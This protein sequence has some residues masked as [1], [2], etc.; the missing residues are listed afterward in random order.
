MKDNK[1]NLEKIKYPLF[2]T[3]YSEIPAK[4]LYLIKYGTLP[5]K[6][7]TT[8][9][10]NEKVI[11]FLL[12]NGYSVLTKSN[13]IKETIIKI[14]PR[15]EDYL[16]INDEFK[17][18][19]S[20][21]LEAKTKTY[22]LIF[23]Y[24]ITTTSI[25]TNSLLTVLEQFKIKESKSNIYIIKS[26]GSGNL[27]GIGYDIANP[28]ID[29]ELNYGKEFKKVHDVIIKRLNTENDKGIILL[30]GKSGTGKTY[31]LRYLTKCIDN[32]EIYFVPPALT[33]SLTDPAIIPFLME[34]K[35]SILIIED[36]EKIITDRN[37]SSSSNGVANILNLTDGILGD[38]LNI[39]IIVTFN[40]ERSQIDKAMT[41]KGRLIAEHSFDCLN[42]EDT[43]N[44]LSALGKNRK[45]DKELTLAEIYNIDEEEYTSDKKIKIGFK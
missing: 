5:S 17:I 44:L 22:W 12:S 37:L 8:A 7:S 16:L 36:G 42:V 41:R 28:I 4:Q 18:F 23:Y 21:E 26:D 25:E 34:R 3:V 19:I 13:C 11:E 40:M 24:D 38:C 27:D 29:I 6:Y 30:H 15:E 32:K 35:N 1:I 20:I 9:T 31:Y 33:E 39:Q 10:Y 45:S 2:D 43:N 14:A